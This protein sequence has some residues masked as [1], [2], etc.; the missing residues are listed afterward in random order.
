MLKI[1][2]TN[3][4]G[5]VNELNYI[6]K[7]PNTL[8]YSNPRFI[9]L[10]EDHLKAKSKWLTGRRGGNVVGM[11]PYIISE[12]VYGPVFNSL[13][14]FGSNG[15]VIQH[16][17]DVEAKASIID[18]FFKEAAAAKAAAATVISNPLESDYKFYENAIDGYMVDKRIG[19]ITH[20][21]P[22]EDEEG[23]IRH[24]QDPRPRNIRR[25]I[26]EGVVVVKQRDEDAI[27]F[28][29]ETHLSNMTAIGGLPK[30]K[31][32]FTSIPEH[33]NEDE[34]AIFVANREGKPIAALLVFYFNNT[35]EYF[36]PVILEKYRNT[37]A[38][39]LIIYI[40][41]KDAIHHGYKNWNWGGTWLSQGGVYNFKK[42][43][44]TSE[45]NYFY[46]TKLY[47]EEILNCTP[48]V[49]LQNYPGFFVVPYKYLKS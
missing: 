31:S 40:A 15:G 32:F 21:P 27:S 18:T 38:L 4:A 29:Y 25:A 5:G 8:V 46:Y 45:Y 14:Y 24:F 11:M 49:L 10:V 6:T 43:W 1:E 36:T 17:N 33:M 28:L 26:R 16:S 2:L 35:V 30:S 22:I 47:N 20:L 9:R 41:M 39:A 13:A 42:R 34:W 23:L 48:S 12:G 7:N 19:Q 44:G 3:G 37:Q